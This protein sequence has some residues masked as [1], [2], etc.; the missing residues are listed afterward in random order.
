MKTIILTTSFI[1]SAALICS[2]SSDSV[3][4]T[5]HE[6]TVIGISCA[7]TDNNSRI[8]RK[9]SEAIIKAGG[10]PYLLPITEDTA[11]LSGMLD[12]IDALVRTAAADLN[13]A[14]YGE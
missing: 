7:V 6:N 5:G 1:M 11:A 4:E 10:I 14:I 12:G 2:C 3:D 8:G 9:Y 13:P